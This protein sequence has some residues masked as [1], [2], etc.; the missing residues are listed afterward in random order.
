MQPI[1]VH[2]EP[3]GWVVIVQE[4]YEGAIGSTLT[5][6]RAGLVLYG[7]A[8]L[9][10]VVLVVVGLWAFAVRMLKETGPARAMTVHG[11]AAEPIT[12]SSSPDATT[13]L[14]QS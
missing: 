13:Q 9:V 7:V 10:M 14:H 2:G 8:A 3:T 5:K 6:L 12:P 11:G 4:A 1:T